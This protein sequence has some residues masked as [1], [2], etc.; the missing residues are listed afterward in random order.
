MCG[1]CTWGSVWLDIKPLAVIP[2]SSGMRQIHL[3]TTAFSCPYKGLSHFVW[4]PK[5]LFSIKSNRFI[6]N[7]L[8]VVCSGLI[9]PECSVPFNIILVVLYFKKV[10]LT[11]SFYI[12]ILYL[13]YYIALVFFSSGS[14]PHIFQ[15]FISIFNFT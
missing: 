2:L 15:F 14:L 12:Y 7:Y 10:F 8:S 4:M 1:S 3:L 11:P 5:G 13:L 9:F 6:L